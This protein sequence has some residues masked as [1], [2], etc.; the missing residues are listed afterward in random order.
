MV[1]QNLETWLA[2]RRAGRLVAGTTCY[3]TCGPSAYYYKRV[4]GLNFLSI[5]PN[6]IN[7]VLL[8]SSWSENFA[9]R[10]SNAV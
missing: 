10:P 2:Q 9:N 1:R 3:L 4:K 7:L 8:G 6:C 5:H